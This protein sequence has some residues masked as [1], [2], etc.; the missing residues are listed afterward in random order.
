MSE[1]AP[2]RR[3]ALAILSRQRRRSAFAR[4]L[5]RT[6]SEMDSLGP[7]ARALASR[8]VLGAIA[9]SGEIDRRL[10]AH[11]NRGRSHIEPRVLDAFRIS[12]FEVLYL[13]TRPS[14]SVSQGVELVRR[15]NPKAAG[16]ANAILRKLA[17]QDRPEVD[18][19]RT[20]VMAHEAS[21]DD[22]VTASGLPSRLVGRLVSSVGLDATCD[23]CGCQLEPAPIYVAGNR[24]LH[25]PEQ[26]LDLLEAAE[27]EPVGTPLPGVFLLGHSAGLSFSGLVEGV[28]VVVSDM[29]SQMSALV[30]TPLPGT[31]M[32]EVGAGR[33]TKT[34][35]LQSGAYSLGGPA[36]LVCLDSAP[37]KVKLARERVS[38]GWAEHVHEVVLD[39]TTLAGDA[40]PEG[41]EGPF[42]SIL[43]D[44]PCSGTGTMRR[45]PE[46][47]WSLKEGSLDPDVESSLPSLQLR[48]LEAASARVRPGGALTYA[49]CSVL[50]EEDED[51]V[52]AFLA[53]EQGA[54]FSL[55]SVM[56]APAVDA[57]A[58]EVHEL[59]SSHLSERG[60][61]RSC[62]TPGSF[63]G[64]FCARLVRA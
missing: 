40:L 39:A 11:L 44:A 56:E 31:D 52:D 13:E 41:L 21:R 57:S 64:H 10:T 37:Y 16:L 20:A 50:A 38:H 26:T 43:V 62:P 36:E 23:L 18:A 58:P 25:D 45:H 15:V 22:L 9:A 46:I 7:H 28:D 19:A 48:I 59:V 29:G 24:A 5:L 33:A 47:P 34:I 32:L 8:L 14:V 61:L 60:C 12:A 6:S 42:D 54:G 4:D 55:V 30:A 53:S 17:D 63:D 2:A 35:L 1:A 3:V 27:L 49:T 51:V